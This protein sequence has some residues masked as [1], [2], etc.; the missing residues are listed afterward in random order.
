V[1]QCR[2]GAEVRVVIGQFHDPS[3]ELLTFAR[4]LGLTG[5]QVNTPW[6]PGERRWETADLVGLRERCESRGLVLEAIENIPQS[7]YERAMLG[8][9]GRDEEIENVRQTIRNVGRAGIAILGYH[10]CPLGVVRTGMDRRGRGGAEVTSFDLDAALDPANAVDLLVARRNGSRDDA[11]HL[12]KDDFAAGGYPDLGV[13]I[14]EEQMWENYRY[15]LAGVLPAAEEAG[16]RL[17]I[18]P[19]DP[20]VPTLGGVA[21]IIRSVDA[22]KRASGLV[23][24]P[25]WAVELC[26]GTVSEMG[27]ET[28]VLAAIEHFG[29]RGQ[30]GY[31]HLRDVR[32]T[33]PA[34]EECFLGEG[35]YDPYRVVQALR[36]SGFDGFILDDHTPR[37][38][39]DTEWGH[40]GRAHA[41]GYIQA[42]IDATA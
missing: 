25:A 23:P 9:P 33:L 12:G 36:R 39:G 16:V 17:A 13:E 18:H 24:S 2:C 27:G 37:L 10:F 8:L 28:A 19:D 40:R 26:L 6:L 11:E 14:G 7:F 32:G 35:N 31:V 15:F 29:P 21:R 20:P 42:L 5:I 34:F 30:I 38:V 22:L 3:D 1:R 4:Q 41:V